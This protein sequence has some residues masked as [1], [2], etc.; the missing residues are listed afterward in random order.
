M[1]SG[2]SAT[3]ARTWGAVDSSRISE[4]SRGAERERWHS[5]AAPHRG[6][7]EVAHRAGQGAAGRSSLGWLP[8]TPLGLQLAASSAEHW[9]STAAASRVER[10]AQRLLPA[11]TARNFR[12]SFLPFLPRPPKNTEPPCTS[13]G[14]V[15]TGAEMEVPVPEPVLVLRAPACAVRAPWLRSSFPPA[16][17]QPGS[18]A[19]RCRVFP[20]PARP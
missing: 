4:T 6:P 14:P 9:Q 13:P 15:G 12:Q 17:R 16:I 5:E 18:P 20:A 1:E 3:V 7:A 19:T 8:A 11:A 10:P 2:R